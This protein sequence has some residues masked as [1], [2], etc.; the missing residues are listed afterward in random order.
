MTGEPKRVREKR[1]TPT[2]QVF[3][4]NRVTGCSEMAALP[5]GLEGDGCPA[6]P[7]IDFCLSN[8]KSP[9]TQIYRCASVYR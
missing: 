9:S 3:R 7:L 1:F 8:P 5:G 4:E 6:R 2:A